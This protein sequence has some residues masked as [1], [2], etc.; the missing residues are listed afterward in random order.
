MLYEGMTLTNQ[1]CFWKKDVHQDLGFLLNTRLNF[2]YEWFLR[3]LKKFPNSGFHLNKTLGCFRI[4]KGQK[5]QNQSDVDIDLLNE[6]KKKYGY[7]KKL[8]L[9]FKTKLF[10]KRI[11]H[12]LKNKNFYYLFRGSY[13]VFFGIKNKEYI[14]KNIN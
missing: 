6:I 9:Y 11:F 3:F 12:H 1:A 5:S 14:D 10:I 4:Y 13:K 7:S 8:F 2:E